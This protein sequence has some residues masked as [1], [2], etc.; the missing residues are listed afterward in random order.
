M[1]VVCRF[2]SFA[3]EEFAAFQC[4][5]VSATVYDGVVICIDHMKVL[6]VNTLP[7]SFS[8]VFFLTQLDFEK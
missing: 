3:S 1:I 8:A 2:W 6:L 4:G 5:S 7:Q